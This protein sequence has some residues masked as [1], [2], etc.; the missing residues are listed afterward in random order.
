MSGVFPATRTRSP[1]RSTDDFVL[2]LWTA[3]AELAREADA[4]GVERI[5]VDLE[6]LG[7]AERQRGL[8]TWISPHRLD[9]LAGV[10]SALRR[11]RL[12]ARVN[13]IHD[14]SAA[15]VDAV[16]ACGA[17][18]LMLPM[19]ATAGE[20]REFV[21]MVGGAA[22]VVL[23]VER[24]QALYELQE[25]ADV[26]GV[27]EVHIGLNDLAL[28]LGLR[29]RWLTLAGDLALNAGAVVRASGKRFGLGAVGRVGDR[30]LPVPVDLVYAEYARTGATAALLSRSFF[31]HGVADLAAEITSLR[32]ELARWTKR[33][34][35]ELAAAHRE[36]A[37]RAA[38]AE[39]F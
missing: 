39:C 16:I 13:P 33:S 18:V 10:R 12:F 14:R 3:D 9:D 1:T 29:N 7:K 8:G 22:T 25:L 27:D 37:R 11:A 4:A 20:A 2:T 6:T 35:A 23:L 36:L 26:D 15:E 19:V 34:G 32:R 30:G 5:G 38:R 24:V 17:Q 31:R 21:R 28:S